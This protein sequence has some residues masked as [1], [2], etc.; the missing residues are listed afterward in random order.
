MELHGHKGKTK[1]YRLIV[2]PYECI[3]IVDFYPHYTHQFNQ[4]SP[5]QLI[6]QV[7]YEQQED[8]DKIG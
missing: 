7:W 5:L 8:K 6:A 4:T 1:R 2:L 3:P